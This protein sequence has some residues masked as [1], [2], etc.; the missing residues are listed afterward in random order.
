MNTYNLLSDNSGQR[1]GRLV[2]KSLFIL[3]PIIVVHSY[4]VCDLGQPLPEKAG[5]NGTGRI[6]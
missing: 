5:I 6:R 4:S 1:E 2:Y 3:F